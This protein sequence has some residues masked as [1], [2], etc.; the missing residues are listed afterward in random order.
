MVTLE[1]ENPISGDPIDPTDAGTWV[2]YA[3]GGTAVAGSLL[4]GRRVVKNIGE[5]AD[6]S[7]LPLAGD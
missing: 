7:G 1:G 6:E 3:V 2:K 4:L 5:A